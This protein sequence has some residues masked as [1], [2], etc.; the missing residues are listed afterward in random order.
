[1]KSHRSGRPGR[2]TSSNMPRG[3][4]PWATLGAAFSDT[5]AVPQLREC[6]QGPACER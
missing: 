1:M 3:R 6:E 2:T 4:A 5:P